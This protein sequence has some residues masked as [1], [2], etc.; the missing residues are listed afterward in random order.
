MKTKKK[1]ESNKK[2]EKDVFEGEEKEGSGSRETFTKMDSSLQEEDRAK[3]TNSGSRRKHFDDNSQETT[4][5]RIKIIDM[6][7]NTMENSLDGAE[8][9]ASDSGKNRN[10][11]FSETV[12]HEADIAES[13]FGNTV[14]DIKDRR[15]DMI[16]VDNAD[17]QTENALNSRHDFLMG[18]KSEKIVPKMADEFNT[19][20]DAADKRK[21]IKEHFVDHMRNMAENERDNRI[22]MIE[23][24]I[25]SGIDT[26]V[27]DG[28]NIMMHN[29]IGNIENRIAGLTNG[30]QNR[31][32]EDKKPNFK[33]TGGIGEETIDMFNSMK[34]ITESM[35]VN[36]DDK[37]PG[38]S[39]RR[40]MIDD[41]R[42][43]GENIRDNNLLEDEVK[44]QDKGRFQKEPLQGIS[45]NAA[46]FVPGIIET[47]FVKD[48]VTSRKEVISNDLD[49]AT[50]GILAGEEPIISTERRQNMAH[51]VGDHI[52]GFLETV[53]DRKKNE[54][55]S[56]K[57]ANTIQDAAERRHGV[58]GTTVDIATDILDSFSDNRQKAET[59]TLKGRFGLGQGVTERRRH[60]TGEVVDKTEDILE[61]NFDNHPNIDDKVSTNQQ[62]ESRKKNIVKVLGD[63][64]SKIF[65]DLGL[66]ITDSVRRDFGKTP[67][68]KSKT[69][70]QVSP[71]NFHSKQAMV[72][73]EIIDKDV[74]R[75]KREATIRNDFKMR[76]TKEK[77]ILWPEA[78]EM[79]EE[80][81]LFWLQP[82]EGAEKTRE[83]RSSKIHRRCLVQCNEHCIRF[84]NQNSIV[85]PKVGRMNLE[86]HG[87]QEATRCTNLCGR[88]CR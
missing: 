54:N 5:S 65:T 86:K 39:L 84:P 44:Q 72:S 87:L 51:S 70:E 71:L 26:M 36:L 14:E 61:T 85:I 33:N 56:S 34:D 24:K 11:I 46:A 4:D 25:D 50:A 17:D 47:D 57:R 66:K 81:L 19:A 55:Q 79:C 69:G 62:I 75:G 35:V 13:L 37:M 68:A 28:T 59:D 77:D 16:K 32:R 74:S 52:E 60:M 43:L 15:N 20:E 45:N 6:E 2:K 48:I 53:V 10:N 63:N 40:D 67:V 30:N 80:S 76:F 58:V 21:Y 27:T 29:L 78:A 12:T 41:V 7:E 49:Q 1:K 82:T 88:F 73:T 22:N 18:D 83:R 64:K 9:V 23:D 38:G 42:G 31:E 3:M 8:N